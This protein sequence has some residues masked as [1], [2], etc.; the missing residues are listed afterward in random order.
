MKR[1]KKKQGHKGTKK[2]E[3]LVDRETGFLL[4]KNVGEMIKQHSR[5]YGKRR[6]QSKHYLGQSEY[7]YK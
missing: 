4:S 7:E 5:L 1:K 2:N 6:K 3:N